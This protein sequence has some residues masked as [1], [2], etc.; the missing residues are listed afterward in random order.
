MDLRFPNLNPFGIFFKKNREIYDKINVEDQ[1]VS[2]SFG[3]S[4]EENSFRNFGAVANNS[5]SSGYADISVTGTNFNQVFES[6]RQKITKYREMA[7]FPEVQDSTDTVVDDCIIG[8]QDGNILTLDFNRDIPSNIKIQ[9]KYLWKY[10]INDVLDFNNNGWDLFKRFLVD[11]EIYGEL[12]LNN[13]HN[14]I[15][16]VKILP[17]WNVSPLYVGS[18]IKGFSQVS[19]KTNQSKKQMDFERDQIAYIKYGFGSTLNDVRGYYEAAIKSYNQLKSMED[20]VVVYRL[21]RAVERRAWNV[22]TGRMPK[23]KAEMYVKNLMQKFRKK[24]IYDPQTGA[25]NT[26]QNVTSMNED[27]W[28]TKGAEGEGTTVETIAGGLNLGELTDVEYFLKK[29]YKT[30]KMPRSRWGDTENNIFSN[31]KSGEITRDEIHLTRF[32]ERVQQKFKPFLL[33]PFLTLLKFRGVDQKYINRGLFNI[34][35]TP[36]NLFKEFKETEILES[37]ISILTQMSN[38]MYSEEHKDGNLSPE[39]VFKKYFRMSDEDWSI[40]KKQIEDMQRKDL[41]VAPETSKEAGE[42]SPDTST[43]EP[44]PEEKPGEFAGGPAPKNEPQK[45]ESVD[46]SNIA[47]KTPEDFSIFDAWKAADSKIINTHKPQDLFQ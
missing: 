38:F 8:N 24:A 23:D 44:V 29:L 7:N 32:E 25:V 9:L 27:Y 13:K 39:F 34:Q 22:Y 6:K 42:T 28:F 40:N 18:V 35:F 17:P 46:V 5:N 11:S 4:Q 15:I 36:S 33:E 20:S 47:V 31:G 10:W 1:K 12:I 21:V 43:E 41:V 19:D 14:N 30:L 37:K 16:G 3:V 45:E 26:T 2:N